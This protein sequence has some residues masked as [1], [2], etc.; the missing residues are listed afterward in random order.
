[1]LE[2]LMAEFKDQLVNIVPKKTKSIKKPV[3]PRS[4]DIGDYEPR[5]NPLR[6]VR[7]TR[8]TPPKT[9]SRRG[10]MSSTASSFS[11]DSLSPTESSNSFQVR[12]GFFNKRNSL[13]E[14]G[15]SDEEYTLPRRQHR[16]SANHDTRSAEEITEEDLSRVSMSGKKFYDSI[17]GTTCHQCRQK[18]SDMK[19]ICRKGHCFGVR[20][21]F[22]G[23]C[24][25]NRY[26]ED[27]R[28][29][30]KDPDWVCPPC[31]G[32]C[33][34]SFCRKRAGKSCTGILIHLAR[35]LG[36]SDVN[37]LLESRRKPS[38]LAEEL[39]RRQSAPVVMQT[40]EAEVTDEI[41]AKDGRE[42]SETGSGET[43]DDDIENSDDESE[44]EN[45]KPKFAIKLFK[46]SRKEKPVK[47]DKETQEDEEDKTN[48]SE[49]ECSKPENQAVLTKLKSPERKSFK[50]IFTERMNMLNKRQPKPKVF[51]D[52]VE[53]SPP[54]EVEKK[55]VSPLKS[56]MT[57]DSK[58]IDWSVGDIVW[59]K[60]AGHPWWPCKIAEEEQSGEFTKMQGKSRLYHMNYYGETCETGWVFSSSIMKFEG[61]TAFDEFVSDQ[62]QF[63]RKAEKVKLEKLYKVPGSR[64]H[65]L[66]IAIQE[67]EAAA[68]IVSKGWSMKLSGDAGMRKTAK[69]RASKIGADSEVPA[70]KRMKVAENEETG[71]VVSHEHKEKEESDE[72]GNKVHDEAN[73]EKRI[74]DDF[75][76]RHQEENQF[77]DN[78]A[79]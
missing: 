52:E 78:R 34:C 7:P 44:E 6:N 62:V 21:Q 49:V 33:N 8:L 71:D 32:I 67:A 75:S 13:D 15:D 3:R 31:R 11:S 55:K 4:I 65:A 9:R 61:K 19:T 72:N 58:P 79:L 63:A 27:A 46:S 70:A 73:E 22:C 2:K 16:P 68:G 37:A 53:T 64:L 43:A 24:L 10:S 48:V 57:P 25:K 69:R 60:V 56:P 18:T 30:L 77:E 23:V 5:R 47:I 42:Q 54:K 74:E 14:E 12:F 1:M 36:Y 28:E 50:N 35:E 17:H 38:E 76:V 45:N 51:H 59:G 41:A 40:T 66:K 39:R 29:A 20:G 26:G